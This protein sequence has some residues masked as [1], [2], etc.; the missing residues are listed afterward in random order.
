MTSRIE[1]VVNSELSVSRCVACGF[2]YFS[3]F[4]TEYFY[5][6]VFGK[7]MTKRRNLDDKELECLL[8]E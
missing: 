1:L 5:H 6:T 2:I 3:W 7:E 8:V 4:P